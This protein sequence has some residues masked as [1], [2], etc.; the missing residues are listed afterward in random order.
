MSAGTHSAHD[1]F[2]SAT[3]EEVPT[4]RS[5][6][7]VGER[8][9]VIAVPWRWVIFRLPVSGAVLVVDPQTVVVAPDV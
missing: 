1:W 2:G 9:A 6:L 7:Q 3:A 5:I 4:M 8:S